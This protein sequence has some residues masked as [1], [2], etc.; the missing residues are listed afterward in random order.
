MSIAK[1]LDGGIKI[2]WND[3]YHEVSESRTIVYKK[4][5]DPLLLKH[6]NAVVFGMPNDQYHA[7]RDYISSS[8]L[9]VFRSNPKKYERVY[10]KRQADE[11]KSSEEKEFGSLLHCLA[12]EPESFDNLYE[13]HDQGPDGEPLNLRRDL[14]KDW[15]RVNEELSG[16]RFIT[17]D[18]YMEALSVLD[19]VGQNQ[20]AEKLISGSEF[21]ELSLFCKHDQSG[22]RLKAKLDFATM[23]EDRPTIIDLKSTSRDASPEGWSKEIANWEYDLSAAMY[24]TVF[25]QI[26]GEWPRFLWVAVQRESSGDHQ[27]LIHELTNQDTM[28]VADE[29]RNL[30]DEMT[31]VSM[32]QFENPY[33]NKINR[34]SLPGWRFRVPR[35]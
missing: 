29:V 13:I 7:D 28:L 30:L 35:G 25:Q 4:N 5:G 16:K 6:Y 26:T 21:R 27:C 1:L 10:A 31:L 19:A 22:L 33:S 3:E 34:V 32:T 8:T 17:T 2:E 12:A 18:Y 23:H 11:N 15:K 9:K 24:C 14:H 20:L